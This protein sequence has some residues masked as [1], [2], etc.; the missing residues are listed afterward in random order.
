M[1]TATLTCD[2]CDKPFSVDD[3]NIGDKVKC[4][5]CADVSVVRTLAARAE[6]DRAAA[7]GLPAKHGP[8]V[9]VRRLRNGRASARW[10]NLT[11]CHRPI[12]ARRRGAQA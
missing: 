4:P 8:E 6:E 11:A 1:P 3:V 10:T 12:Q 2:N 7:A 5:I 9:E